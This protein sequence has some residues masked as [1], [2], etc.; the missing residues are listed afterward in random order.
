VGTANTRPDSRVP[1]RV[2]RVSTAISPTAIATACGDRVGIAE[3]T[4]STPEV[5]DTATVIT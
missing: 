4:A 2:A 3:V 5:T 1:R